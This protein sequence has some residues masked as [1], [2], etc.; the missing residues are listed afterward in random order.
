[1]TEDLD[2]LELQDRRVTLEL[3]VRE[4]YLVLMEEREDLVAQALMVFLD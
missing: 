2:S 4:A 3:M 1:M